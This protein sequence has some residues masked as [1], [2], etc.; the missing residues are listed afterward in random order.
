MMEWLRKYWWALIII[1]SLPVGINFILLIPAF[2]PVVGDNVAWLS[3]WGSYFAS[4][5]SAGTAFAILYIQYQ[6]N[7]KENKQNRELQINSLEYQKEREQLQSIIQISSKL[8]LLINPIEIY[9]ELRLNEKCLEKI[10]SILSEIKNTQQELF[11]YLG[12]NNK[13]KNSKLIADIDVVILDYI[14]AAIDIQYLI[15]IFN[16][17]SC[18]LRISDFEEGS[19]L[20]DDISNELRTIILEYRESEGRNLINSDFY[21]I[22]TKRVGLIMDIQDKLSQIITE[23]VIVEKERIGKI[24]INSSINLC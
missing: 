22:A 8:I 11:L 7:N 20:F 4:I 18:E 24:L 13:I 5:I 1:L 17:H 15:K 16:K 3:F 21:K 6:Q 23:F 14:F 9:K 19:K 2:T 10:N 12:T